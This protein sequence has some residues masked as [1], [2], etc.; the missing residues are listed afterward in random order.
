MSASGS[1]RGILELVE[2]IVANDLANI[3]NW[4]LARDWDKIDSEDAM[5]CDGVVV[6]NHRIDCITGFHI[7][8]HMTTK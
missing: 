5:V 1:F 3:F 4:N 8:G 7:N 2:F 6:G